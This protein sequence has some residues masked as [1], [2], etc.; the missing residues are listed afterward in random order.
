MSRLHVSLV[1]LFCV[2]LPLVASVAAAAAAPAA[3]VSSS[4]RASGIAGTVTVTESMSAVE[5][6][7][8]W[9]ATGPAGPA[10]NVSFDASVQVCTMSSQATACYWQQLGSATSSC[11]NLLPSVVSLR[12]SRGALAPLGPGGRWS[13]RVSR[14]E[15]PNCTGDATLLASGLA[16]GPRQSGQ[17]A[18]WDIGNI[19][20]NLTTGASVLPNNTDL[21]YD[22]DVEVTLSGGPVAPTPD[23]DDG[24]GLSTTAVSLIVAGAILVALAA[25]AFCYTANNK[26]KAALSLTSD[27][28]LAADTGAYSRA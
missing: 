24:H 17:T 18:G 21:S 15:S 12:V 20:Y 10:Y 23:A 5:S 9:T 8:V 19:I 4:S 22:W 3:A 26:R 6:A 13:L 1:L 25:A 7:P 14:F 11:V 28:L 27:A 2:A 16:N